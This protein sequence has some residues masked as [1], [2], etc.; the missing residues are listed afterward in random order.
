MPDMPVHDAEVSI[1]AALVRRLVD[2]QFPRWSDLPLRPVASAGT[3]N[4]LLRLGE[5]MVVRLPRIAAAT[6]QAAKEHRWLPRLAPL[7]PLPIPTPVG[8]GTPG[9]GYPWSWS[10]YGWL[11][12]EVGTAGSCAD[13]T[14]S[15]R[16]LAGFI[17]ALQRI[18]ADGGP[19]PGEHNFHRGEP[20]S[21]R[22]VATRASI[23]TLD[24]PVEAAAATRAWEEALGAPTWDG[25][26]TWIHGDLHAGNILLTHGTVSAVID[27]GGL[28][29][30]DPAC[31]LMAAWTFLPARAREV[32][33]AALAAAGVAVADS[34]WAR[35]RG[36][37]LSMAVIALP[38]YRSR[39]P[40]LAIEAR[41]WLGEVLT[42]R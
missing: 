29:I 14:G 30:G 39:N 41:R 37:A 7:L 12:G 5:E 23:A 26:P 16:A 32:F 10:V 28:A 27:F 40:P 21:T 35:A 33:R 11:P 17:A 6:Q 22:D 34:A 15:A 42:D 2:S 25:P 20:L 18:P 4:A 9:D 19:I 8:R 24:D 38:Y 13:P 31:D 1:D 3:D 36:W